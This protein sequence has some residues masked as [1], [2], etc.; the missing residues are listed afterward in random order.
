MHRVDHPTATLANL[1]TEGSVS[2][3]VPAT[4]VP[5]DWLNDVQE[6]LALAIEFAG[7]A[8][9]KGNY[10]QL[11]SAI[12]AIARGIVPKRTFTQNDFIRI[13]DVP[14]GL[15]IQWG[16]TGTLSNSAF[17]TVTLPV[18]YTTFK[19]GAVATQ[20]GVTIDTAT[21]KVRDDAALNSIGVLASNNT[22][23]AFYISAGY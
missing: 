13:P 2:G 15:I 9:D 7:I 22:A 8:L 1:F 18:A 20:P 10:G 19:I 5:A 4:I 16:R 12:V 14:G 23:N 17:T 21:F 6:N 11:A 3:G